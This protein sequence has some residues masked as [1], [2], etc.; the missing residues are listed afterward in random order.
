MWHKSQ[1]SERG[2][3]SCHRR[4]DGRGQ[5]AAS[6]RD[7]TGRTILEASL[8]AQ[9][10]K[11]LHTVQETW[12][13][14]LSK[15]DLLEKGMTAHSS[16]FAW[17]IPWAGQP[18]GLHSMGSQRVGHDWATDTFLLSM[19]VLGGK[20]FLRNVMRSSQLGHHPVCNLYWYKMPLS[21]VCSMGWR[22]VSQ[23]GPTKI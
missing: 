10:I 19:A 6:P 3:R 1:P 7:R 15:E 14:S 11:K 17:R 12:V 18:S 23:D 4:E 5:G 13:R 9:P 21:A 20:I 16:I 8:V 2:G 22:G